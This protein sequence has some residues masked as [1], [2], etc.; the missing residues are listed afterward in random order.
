MHVG[1]DSSSRAGNVTLL[2]LLAL[3]AAIAAM[4]AGCSFRQWGA[5]TAQITGGASV[6]V[7]STPVTGLYPGAQR[8]LLLFLSNGDRR[9]SA[10]VGRVVVSAVATTKPGCAPSVQNLRVDPYVGPPFT[11][12][13][14]SIRRLSLALTMPNTVS[15][16]C[17]QAIF[18]LRYTAQF[19]TGTPTR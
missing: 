17:Q 1:S 19:W 18:K 11:I 16:A 2:A 15:N 12:P 5:A 8:R 9:R 10:L 6:Q 3:F 7:T 13:P 4:G 14:H